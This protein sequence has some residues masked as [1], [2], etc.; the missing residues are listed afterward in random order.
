MSVS[1]R[2]RAFDVLRGFSVVSMVL[3]HFCY[4][5]KFIAGKDPSWFAPP[6]QD[7]WRA[8]ISWVFLFVAGCMCS[9]SRNNLRR[10]IPYCGVACAIFVVTTIAAVD[11]PISFG[12]MFCIGACTLIV[13]LLERAGIRPHSVPA[14]ILFMLCFALTLHVPHEYVGWGS[15]RMALPTSWYTTPWFSWLGLPGPGF[16]SGD[17]YPVIP[18]LFMYLCGTA[19]GWHWKESGYPPFLQRLACPP[20]EWVGRNAL[21]IYVMHQPILL[22]IS[23]LVAT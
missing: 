13:G 8:S 4:D 2:F 15:M 17:Y 16:S 20:L 7:I 21:P 5:L 6:L 10:A 9:F 1:P 14:A 11:T 12:I 19:M 18:F 3:F 23:S 22:L